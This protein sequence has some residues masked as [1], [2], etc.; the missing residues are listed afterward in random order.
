MRRVLGIGAWTLG[1]VLALIVAVGAGVLIAANTAPGRA[2]LEHATA[3]FSHGKVQLTG[4]SGTFPAAIDVGELRLSDARGVWL[5]A[6]RISLRWSPL[7]L[8]TRHVQVASLQLARLDIE[9]RPVSQPSENSSSQQSWPSLDVSQLSIDTLELG[10]ELTGV[11]ATL[12][13]QGTAHLVSPTD[14]TASIS[15]HRTNGQGSYQIRLRG[16]PSRLDA[17]VSLEEPAGG[18]LESLLRLP[19]LGALSVEGSL[20]GPRGAEQLQLT[21]RAGELHAIAQGNLDITRA[22]ADLFYRLEAPAMTPR[23]GLSWQLLTMTGVWHGAVTA[24]HTNAR[25]EV[26]RLQIP[27]G[28]ALAR[29]GANLRAE[30]SDLTAQATVEGLVLPGSQPRLLASSPLRLTATMR[31]SDASRPLRLTADHRLFSL[32]A[33]AV[34]TGP[35]R[36]SFALRLPDL[37]PLAAIAGE[38]VRGRSELKGMFQQSSAAMRLDLDAD[39]ELADGATLLNSMLAGASHLKLAA[40]WTEQTIEVGQL[41]LNGRIVSVSA[42]GSA[43]R[44]ADA[45]TLQ[46]LRARYEVDVANLAVLSPKLA[47]TLKLQGQLDGPVTSLASQA[48][49]TS[50]LSIQ[51]TQPGTVEASITARGL[52]ALVSATVRAHG[53]LAG[54]PLQLDASLD[55]VAG[56]SLR[57]AVRRADWQSAHV[58]GDLTTAANGAPGRGVLRLRMERL[59]DLQPLLGTSVRGSI[60]GSLELKSAAGRTYTQLRLDASNLVAAEVPAS[61]HLSASGPLNALSLQLSAHSPDLRGE[62][63][64]L[65]TRA[66]LNFASRELRLEQVEA[67]YHKL[68]LRLRAPAR[69]LFAEGLEVRS[70]ELGV[71]SALVD[72]DGRVSPALELHASAHHV[73]A[74]LID[75]FA[76]D[77]LGEGTVDVDAQLRGTA[78]APAG[79]VTVKA[80][81]LRPA[82]SATRDLPALDVSA[83]ARLMEVSARVDAHLSAGQA[84]QLTLTGAAPLNSAGALSL[85]LKGKLEAGVVNPLLEARGARVAGILAVNV[86]VTGTARAPEVGGTVDF[87]NGDLRDYVQGVHLSDISAHLVGSQGTLRI[88]S[89]AARAGPGR[90]SVT[91][92]LGVLQRQL[93]L[94]LRITATDAQP[95]TNDILTAN[96]NADLKVAGTLRERL[97]V[98]GTIDVNRAVIGIP[99]ALPPDVAVLDV[100]RPG[101]APPAPPERQ[102]VIGL[103]VKVDAPREILVQGR[104][105]DAELGGDLQIGGTTANPSVGGGFDMIRGTFTL[106]STQLTFSKGRVTFNGAGLKGKIDPTLDFTAQTTAADA[107]VT[108]QITGLA[109]AP[110]L[111]LSSTP[112]LPQDEILARLLFGESAAQLTA[113]QLAQI[114]AALVSLSGVGGSGPNPL[115]RVQKAL[116]LDRLSVGG[117][118]S[119]TGAQATQTSGATVEAGRYV[120]SR[121][122]VGVKQSTTGFSQA[123]VD[124][125]LSK[126]LKLQSR[127]GNGT[128]TTQ[129]T[130]PENDPGSS[131]GMVYQFQY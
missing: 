108:L 102:L 13:V 127:L 84:S 22:A 116:G 46:S 103:S 37:A 118:T 29:L 34:T 16:D 6:Q 43:R 10:P 120:S 121:V 96:L 93:P 91:G 60:S 71:R 104:G 68:V 14:A 31:L 86:S 5:T 98:S 101:Q 105:L 4:L 113:L 111:E 56:N 53:R 74:G 88:E 100:R 89:L 63:G 9:R 12:S 59:E 83:T 38:Q 112:S 21:V 50:S 123:E 124:V 82:G 62:P 110:Q 28:A 20:K 119:T 69:V 126:H 114:G 109:D 130:S 27:G 128:A 106:A 94:A 44:A 70:L 61:V 129:G 42:N 41:V 47:G 67:H 122:F 90:L 81:G 99:N 64:S 57:L 11:P 87:T 39:N 131:I 40:T 125:D 8:L 115:A 55:R 48:Q 18:A 24:P 7:A 15:A 66:E 49:L 54:A 45:H 85:E 73:D 75:A 117:G 33:Q 107:T 77:L 51:G 23:A 25:L 36:G 65:D 2:W 19:G 26:D 72:I 35:L 78:A 52:P 92:E 80:T 79:I 30:G 97:D 3:R 58:E 17:T 76:P 95:I 1:S 32:Q